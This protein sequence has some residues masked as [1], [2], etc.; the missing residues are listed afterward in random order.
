[1]S[2]TPSGTTAGSSILMLRK[3]ILVAG[4]LGGILG[5]VFSIAGSRFIK[6]YV[7]T[8]P[9]TDKEKAIADAK[10]VV[11]ALIGQVDTEKHEQFLEQIKLGYTYLSEEQFRET[12]KKYD[13]TRNNISQIYGPPLHKFDLVR[14]TAAS[15]NLVQFIYLQRF[16]H[17]AVVW[18]FIMYKGKDAWLIAFLDWTTLMHDAFS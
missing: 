14:E 3:P 15:P 1:M 11:E 18:R 8:Q 9:P 7:P 12:K 13:T 6:P 16:E 2:E 4:L 17:G 5:A 10:M